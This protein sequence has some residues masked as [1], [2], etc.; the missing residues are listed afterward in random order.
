MKQKYLNR[1]KHL[2]SQINS[3]KQTK[4]KY[5]KQEIIRKNISIAKK[6]AK[7][8]LMKTTHFKSVELAEMEKSTKRSYEIT[9][10]LKG[11]QDQ[12]LCCFLYTWNIIRGS[13]IPKIKG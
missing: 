13:R 11:K 10:A 8:K 2:T 6:D 3:L 7:I 12:T 5:L 9:D 1:V 4:V